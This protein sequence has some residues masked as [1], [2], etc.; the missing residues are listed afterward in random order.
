MLSGKIGCCMVLVNWSVRVDGA[1]EGV[2]C[3]RFMLPLLLFKGG[4]GLSEHFELRVRS[5]MRYKKC[6]IKIPSV[7]V[8]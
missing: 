3:K 2:V 1:V 6:F 7:K 5:K 4:F 8:I